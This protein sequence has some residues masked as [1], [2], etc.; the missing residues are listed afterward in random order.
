MR[1]I[2]MAQLPAHA[3]PA[4]TPSSSP[5]SHFN[6]QLSDFHLDQS[7]SAHQSQP[8]PSAIISPASTPPATP[9]NGTPALDRAAHSIPIDRTNHGP[10][11]QLLERLPEVNCI[12]RARIPTTTGQEMYLHLYQNDSDNKEHLAIVFGTEIR[13][14]SLDAVQPGESEMDRMIRGAY[15]GRLY[16]GRTTSKLH[17]AQAS[18]LHKSLHKPS[19]LAPSALP[20]T[21]LVS[22]KPSVSSTLPDA[23]ID[24]SA[25][26]SY[27]AGSSARPKSSTAPTSPL[28]RIHSECYTGE[29]VWS[30]RC[31]CG[32]QLDEAARLM[33]L[34][35]V[36]PGPGGVIV[37]LR[38]EGR[39]LDLARSSRRITCKIW[40]R[41]LSKQTYYCGIL[42][43]QGA[44]D[45]RLQC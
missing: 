16:P 38:Q 26:A 9:G 3:S 5:R 1:D 39:A 14:R 21:S 29:T 45:S 13:S 31:D 7:A 15:T 20:N 30:A 34:P 40:G 25:P 28:V 6:R 43:T 22:D 2:T 12:V 41:T 8:P 17:G 36:S 10:T 32:E 11:P 37:Y 27:A 19:F 44:M 23:S 42:R 4:L 33:S 18:P 35:S 24:E